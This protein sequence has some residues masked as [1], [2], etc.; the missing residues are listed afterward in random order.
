M[1][2]FDEGKIQGRADQLR[3]YVQLIRNEAKKEGRGLSDQ[4]KE[5]LYLWEQKIEGLEKQIKPRSLTFQGPHGAIMHGMT[6]GGRDYRSMFNLGRDRLDTG[7]FKDC[8]EFLRVMESGR[9]DPR[10]QIRASMGEGIP[11]SGGFSVPTEFAAEWLDASLPNEIVRNLCRVY[12]MDSQTKDVAGFDGADM[13]GGATHGGLT[14]QFL[15]EHAEATPQEG[16]LRK[17]TLTA[18]MAAIYVNSSIELIQDGRDFAENLQVALK[19]SLGYGIDRYCI[20]GSG[21]G[22]PQG[23][24]NAPCKIQIEKE[25]GQQADTIQYANL[26]K[27][28]ARQLNPEKATWVFNPTSIPELLEQSVS[29]GTSGDFVPILNE[30]D[31]KFTIFGRPVYFHPAMPTLG[32]A[33]DC[34]FVDFNFYA[35]GLRKEVWIDQTDAVRWLQRERSFRILMRF[36]GMCTL[37]AAVQPEHGDTLSPIVTLAERA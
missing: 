15:A 19:Q 17:I 13:T 21:A 5:A 14:M 24:L 4:E 12:P 35:L 30:K 37:N 8:A 33:D 22:C 7:D 9:Y 36:D 10:L 6:G 28:F 29:I 20:T 34:A 18:R 23:V 27:M 25:S 16:K 3:E 1:N 2:N 32:D 31:G 11:S 26:K